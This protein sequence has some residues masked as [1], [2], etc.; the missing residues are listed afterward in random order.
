MLAS[1]LH[2]RSAPD[3]RAGQ[4]ALPTPDALRQ[5]LPRTADVARSVERARVA[6][7]DILAGRDPRLIVIVGPCSL[8]DPTEALVYARR[9]ARLA[10]EHRDTLVI[11]MR[12][13]VEK[14]RTT[15]GWKGLVHDPD[16]DGS[17]D[18]ARGLSLSRSLLL[19]ISRLGLPCA[20]ELL[21]P[22]VARYL[23]DLIAWGSIGARTAQSQP[24]RE[25]ASG[26]PAPIGVKNT[27]DGNVQP[28]ID[29]VESA[30]APHSAL[31]IDLLGRPVRQRTP[32]NPTAH[33]VLRGGSRGPNCDRE[34]IERSARAVARTER[35]RP[36]LV[37][38]S[39][40]N[41]GKDHRL[42][43]AVVR[44]LLADRSPKLAGV[45][46]ESN[47]R[48]GRQPW[49]PGDCPRPGLSIT[50]ACLGWAATRRLVGEVAET[51]RGA[52]VA[53]RESEILL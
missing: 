20:S 2:L 27:T 49:R 31:S 12:C 26:Y 40:G 10:R 35:E 37:D 47:L 14:P 9:L 41:S 21:D 7:R 30:R 53:P 13:Y 33:I 34:T 16:L 25:L 6:V 42:Q 22:I 39:H 46:I 4:T 50:D 23:E 18:I 19:S 15:L 8:H 48:A 5:T 29:A 36:I 32:G 3:A 24:H 43:G 51:L 38:C 1:D 28:A 11:A 17:G 45:M 44:R 52:E